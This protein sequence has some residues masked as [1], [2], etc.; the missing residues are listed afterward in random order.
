MPGVCNR[1]VSRCKILVTDLPLS[2]VF[3]AHLPQEIAGKTGDPTTLLHPC[4]NGVPHRRAPVLVVTHE[5][6]TLVTIQ[7]IRIGVEV[8]QCRHVKLVA[9]LFRPAH[10]VAFITGPACGCVLLGV[11]V[12]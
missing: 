6:G 1:V 7:K 10:K 8:V 4:V 9:L 3:E 2:V 12:R 5:D 11:S